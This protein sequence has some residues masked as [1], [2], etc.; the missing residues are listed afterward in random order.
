MTMTIDHHGCTL[1]EYVTDGA[2]P[3]RDDCACRITYGSASDIEHGHMVR[4]ATVTYKYKSHEE[5]TELREQVA[6]ITGNKYSV[7][8][9][10]KK[11]RKRKIVL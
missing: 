2:V 8:V 9:K 4:Y 6:A 5:F 1:Y 10:K 3:G 11:R 7:P